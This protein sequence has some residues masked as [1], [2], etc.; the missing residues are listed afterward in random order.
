MAV[1]ISPIF[2]RPIV[3]SIGPTGPAG[4]ATGPTGPLGA[5]GAIGPTGA[6][7][8]TGMTG[9]TGTL[10]GPT[11]PTGPTGNTG[12]PLTS[13]P[14]AFVSGVT[15]ARGVVTMTDSLGATIKVLVY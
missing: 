12:P 3:L 11:G 10:T 8:A 15:A 5:T 14:A 9:A 2:T 6:Q 4:G 7:G 1:A 13:L